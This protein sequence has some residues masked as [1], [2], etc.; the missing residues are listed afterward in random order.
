MGGALT[1]Q[2]FL[3]ATGQ[4]LARAGNTRGRWLVETVLPQAAIRC[5]AADPSQPGVAY[6]GTD[7]DGVLRS[8]DGGATWQPAGL[9]GQAIRALAVSQAQPVR[10]YAGTKPPRLFVSDD[11][12]ESWAELTTFRR[13]QAFWW[14]SPA[15]GSPFTPYVQSLVLSPADAGRIVAGIELG[16]VLRSTD[17]GQSW[18]GH[19]PGSLR[20]CHG[21][22][23]HALQPHWVYE[24]G[25]SGAGVAYSH[26]GGHTWRQP[27]HGLD[28]H[29]GWAVA[30]D[31]ALP[32]VWYA[33]LSPS[34]FKAH[35][36]GHAQAGIYRWAGVGDW[37][38]LSGGL[39][40]PLND[41][42]YALLTDPAAPGHL[43][44]G[45]SG[46]EVW[47]SADYGDGWHRLPFQFTGI[48]RSLIRLPSGPAPAP[49]VGSP[50]AAEAWNN[51]P[52]E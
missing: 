32:E 19:R 34:A 28:R 11:G 2:V 9:A 48:H 16:A 20:D 47:H 39:P 25:G 21:L 3:A 41:M 27:R 7:R 30:V 14:F 15:E 17:G 36:A 10:V 43:Y 42:P 29:Y 4:G 18:E 40:D 35:S 24:A 8:P 6:A 44:A 33:S 12:G 49:G 38:R 1:E 45:L 26:N 52:V 46:G 22:A 51:V 31:P 5:L 37:Q 50:Y 13:R 23:A